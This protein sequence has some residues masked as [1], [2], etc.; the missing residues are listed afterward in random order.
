MGFLLPLNQTQF[1]MEALFLVI[2][3][4][5][6]YFLPSI[7]GYS[8]RNASAIVVLNLLLGWTLIGWVVALVW[9]CTSDPPLQTPSVYLKTSDANKQTSSVDQLTKLKALLDS[10]AITQTEYDK[11]KQKILN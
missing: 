11:E 1:I 10:G 3:C 4:G 6:V 5:F 8:K 7:V 2:L 9:A